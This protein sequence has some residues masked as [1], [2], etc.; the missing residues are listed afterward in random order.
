MDLMKHLIFFHETDDK[1]NNE[2]KSR[3]SNKINSKNAM[4]FRILKDMIIDMFSTFI[5]QKHK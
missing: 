4:Y 1:C 3:T 2:Y 5:N